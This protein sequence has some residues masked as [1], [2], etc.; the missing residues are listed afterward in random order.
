MS[1][2]GRLFP[3][4]AV[5]TPNLHEACALAGIPYSEKV[6]RAE[7]AEAIHAL[8]AAAVVVTGGHGAEPMSTGSSTASATCRSRSSALRRGDDAQAGHP[9]GEPRLLAR[10]ESL[11]DAARGAAEIATEAV[12]AGYRIGAG[13]GPVDV[14][15]LASVELGEA[16][17]LGLSSTRTRANRRRRCAARRRAR[18]LAWD[19]LLE[20]PLPLRL[21]VVARPRRSTRRRRPI[22][23]TSRRWGRSDLAAR[24]SRPARGRPT[25]A[26]VALYE[27][28]RA[29]GRRGREP[30]PAT[31]RS[32]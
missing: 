5:V 15:D 21:D 25:R 20:N 18:C 16:G 12:R 19:I 14:L 3:R 7:V 26:M 10:G 32:S 30:K 4:A 13:S 31:S 22:S 17:L 8:G 23:V 2:V 6:E 28:A 9:L 11:E 24:L 29:G 27:R 1:V